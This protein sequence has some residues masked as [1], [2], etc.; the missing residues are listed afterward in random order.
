MIARVNAETLLGSLVLDYSDGELA[1]HHAI[2]VRDAGLKISQ[3][4]QCIGCAAWS[5]D[6]YLAILRRLGCG[7]TPPELLEAVDNEGD[8]SL[9]DLRRAL[10]EDRDD[11]TLPERL[12][13][14]SGVASVAGFAAWS[15]AGGS[16]RRHIG[17]GPG[18]ARVHLRPLRLVSLA[19]APGR[20]F[21]PTV[22]LGRVGRWTLPALGPRIPAGRDLHRLALDRTWTRRA[23]QYAER[24]PGQIQPRVR[25]NPRATTAGWS[26]PESEVIWLSSARSNET[27]ARN[28]IGHYVTRFPPGRLT[29]GTTCHDQLFAEFAA[30]LMRPCCRCRTS[31]CGRTDSR[32]RQDENSGSNHCPAVALAAPLRGGHPRTRRHDRPPARSNRAPVSDR[33]RPS[34]YGRIPSPRNG[35][36]NVPREYVAILR[37]FREHPKSIPITYADRDGQAGN[38][39]DLVSSPQRDLAAIIS[40]TP[41]GLE[42]LKEEGYRYIAPVFEHS[43]TFCLAALA[44]VRPPIAKVRLPFPLVLDGSGLLNGEP[45]DGTTPGRGRL[46]ATTTVLAVAGIAS[47]AAFTQ[48]PTGRSRTMNGTKLP[49]RSRRTG[50][51]IAGGRR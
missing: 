36:V 19:L 24:L 10:E 21:T 13:H 16:P 48:S 40:W 30:V 22:H 23:A 25:F 41:E 33:R 49:E 26:E 3:V 34:A 12:P 14:R 43:E 47:V 8:I 51:G 9:D 17:L 28:A 42:A 39:I 31:A 11:S 5:V 27:V 6:R 7:L 37:S 46:A 1:F 20:R 38:V 18:G 29:E 44:L 4:L 32:R 45:S 15:H 35:Q 50:R 2:P